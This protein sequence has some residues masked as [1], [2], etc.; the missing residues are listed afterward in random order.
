MRY[1][2]AQRLVFTTPEFERWW[3][4]LGRE[5]AATAGLEPAAARALGWHAWR[6]G[7]EQMSEATARD[8]LQPGRRQ[9]TRLG[10]P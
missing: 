6:A 5:V 8:R 10:V 7:R 4:A 1:A 3:D 9:L 2:P